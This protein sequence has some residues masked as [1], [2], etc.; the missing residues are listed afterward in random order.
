[1]AINTVGFLHGVVDQG[2]H[3]ELVTFQGQGT[4]A[5]AFSPTADRFYREG[6]DYELG[7]AAPPYDSSEPTR[8]SDGSFGFV[9][10]IIDAGGWSESYE[11]I[12]GATYGGF[13]T[14]GQLVA[15]RT[16]TMRAHGA[17]HEYQSGETEVFIATHSGGDLALKTNAVDLT[18]SGAP[19]AASIQARQAALSQSF[20]PNTDESV[21]S[22]RFQY[23][24]LGDTIF[25]EAASQDYSGYGI[26]TRTTT[27][28]GLTGST[29]Y[30]FRLR[31]TRTSNNGTDNFGTIGSFTTLADTPSVTTTAATNIGPNGATL[32]GTVNPNAFSDVEFR[33]VYDLDSGTPYA[34]ATAWTPLGFADSSSHQVSVPITGLATSTL[35][36]F[37]LE[38]RWSGGSLTTNGSELS[39]TTE[40]TAAEARIMPGLFE[41]NDRKY[42]VASTFVFTVEVPSATNSNRFLNSAVPWVAG[43]VQISKDAGAPANVATLPVRIGTSPLYQL[44]LSAAEMQATDLDVFLVDA[45]GPAWRDLHIKVQ[46]KARLGKLDIDASQIGTTEQAITLT[47]GATAPGDITGILTSHVLRKAPAQAGATGTTLVLDAS[48]SATNDYYAGAMLYIV[49]GTGAGQCRVITTYNG[50]SKVATVNRGWV[51]TPT[52]TPVF[53]IVPME[54]LWANAAPVELSAVPTAASTPLEKLQALFQRFYFRRKEDATTLTLYKS[55][56]TTVLGTGTNS[57]SA[58]VQDLGKVT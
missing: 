54:E 25:I 40:A 42:G 44:S 17:L 18:F 22:A 13:A 8:L 11:W 26:Q 7:T 30:E 51:A 55:D 52:G 45:D 56:S 15:D 41:Y 31:V 29:T 21:A 57:D 12:A 36:F 4:G 27:V 1:M 19:S 49:S 47:S 34:S 28:T 5:G 32:N 16:H 24:K 6:F 38:V 50:T 14:R 37:R 39:F 3:T 10:S 9:G 35:Y 20:F 23:R 33:F 53:A 48:A 43:D 46:T 2:A 58:G